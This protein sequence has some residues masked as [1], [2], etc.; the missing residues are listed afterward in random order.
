MII[1][2]LNKKIHLAC[3]YLQAYIK[4]LTKSNSLGFYASIK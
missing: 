2:S 3:I 4:I 1:D